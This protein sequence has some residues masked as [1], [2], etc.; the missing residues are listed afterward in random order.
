MNRQELFDAGFHQFLPPRPVAVAERLLGPCN[1]VQRCA[2][3]LLECVAAAERLRQARQ[4]GRLSHPKFAEP[5]TPRYD[6]GSG[7]ESA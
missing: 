4:H 2:G 1:G 7:N 3:A 6:T 5:V